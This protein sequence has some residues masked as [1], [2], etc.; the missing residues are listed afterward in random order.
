[1]Q[2]REHFRTLRYLDQ[3]KLGS[4]TI[5][6]SLFLITSTWTSKL[7]LPLS[8]LDAAAVIT[9]STEVPTNAPANNWVD[10]AFDANNTAARVQAARHDTSMSITGKVAGRA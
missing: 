9:A 2:A 10:D 3:F 1:M 4:Y 5:G 8:P 7:S 6:P